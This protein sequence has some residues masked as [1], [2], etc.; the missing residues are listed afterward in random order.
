MRMVPMGLT[1]LASTATQATHCSTWAGRRCWGRCL[2]AILVRPVGPALRA[3]A[4]VCSAQHHWNRLQPSVTH[5][6]L[7]SKSVGGF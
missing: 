4:I 6:A 1:D 2:G 5:N 7:C 3:T